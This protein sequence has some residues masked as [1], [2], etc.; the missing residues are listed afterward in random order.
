MDVL[1]RVISRTGINGTG[2][3]EVIEEMMCLKVIMLKGMGVGAA[4]QV[5]TNLQSNTTYRLTANVK[6]EGSQF[7]SLGVKEVDGT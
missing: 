1:N 2:A 5:V 7:V 6:I 3:R 4:E